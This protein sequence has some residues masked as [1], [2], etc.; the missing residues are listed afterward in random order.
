[1]VS[2]ESFPE[3]PSALYNTQSNLQKHPCQV[4]LKNE[5]QNPQRTSL[6]H[7]QIHTSFKSDSCSTDC[8]VPR[9][10]REEGGGRTER[11]RE[12][13]LCVFTPICSE[14]QIVDS[15]ASKAP[16]APNPELPLNFLKSYQGFPYYTKPRPNIKLN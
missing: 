13:G 12:E 2:S 5:P 16:M 9:G 7:N 1:M 11:G 10:G 14:P 15:T 6:Y 8:S 3:D 4:S